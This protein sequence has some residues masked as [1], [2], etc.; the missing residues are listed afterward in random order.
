[1]ATIVEII[2]TKERAVLIGSGFGA[3]AAERPS[4]WWGN[5]DPHKENGFL[6]TVAISDRS[7]NI[8]WIKSQDVRVIEID[9]I[10][11]S[12]MDISNEISIPVFKTQ[13]SRCKKALT[14]G[15]TTCSNCGLE[16]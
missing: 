4:L 8:Q 1:M 2:Q 5:L 14:T 9:G 7:G 6:E 11:I 13:C 3:W 16:N 15:N 10:P 12:Q